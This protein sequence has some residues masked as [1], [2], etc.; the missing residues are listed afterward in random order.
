MCIIVTIN[1]NRGS[2]NNN[3]CK[4]NIGGRSS[5]NSSSGSRRNQS[6]T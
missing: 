1:R 2:V 4:S 3:V 5:S 6:R